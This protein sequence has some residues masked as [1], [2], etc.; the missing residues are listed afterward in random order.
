MFKQ[1][2]DNIINAGCQ[3][4]NEYKR[5]SG[6][7]KHHI[8]PKHSGGIDEE[9][10]YTY[11]T[12]REHMIVHYLLWKI[13]K[14]EKDLWSAQFL[15]KKMFIPIDIRKEQSSKGGKIGGKVQAELGLGFHQYKNNPELHKQW[16]SLGGKAHKNKK[17]M[18]KPGDKTFKR[19]TD[20]NIDY[21]LELGY[22]FGSP[23]TPPNKGTKTNKPSIRRKKVSDGSII[24]DSV[25][26]AAS[27]NNITPGAVVYRCKCSKSNWHYVFDNEF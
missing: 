19:V 24:Y 14:N 20:D 2:Y 21:Y 9:I 22:I 11:L 10:N 8:I 7:R 15:K 26:D 13:T 17:V 4:K 27:K 1:I 16:A 5:N 23:F 25:H 3:R 12:E 18:Y 6:L